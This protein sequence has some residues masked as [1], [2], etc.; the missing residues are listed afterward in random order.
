[1]R[2]KNAT[3]LFESVPAR[4]HG[5]SPS[6]LNNQDVKPLSLAEV[7]RLSDEVTSTLLTRALLTVRLQQNELVKKEKEIDELRSRIRESRSR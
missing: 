7:A 4:K 1:M 3:G 2:R 6:L 5:W